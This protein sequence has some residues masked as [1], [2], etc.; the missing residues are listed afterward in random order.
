M[1]IKFDGNTTHWRSS[2]I[3]RVVE[4]AVV[5]AGPT[6]T[7]YVVY[8]MWAR[9][10]EASVAHFTLGDMVRLVI[11][12]PRRGPKNHHD[13]P[14][15]AIALSAAIPVDGTVL[16]MRESFRVANVVGHFVAV[17][18]HD[19]NG[20]T[21]LRP[22]VSIDAQPTWAPIETFVIR[23]YKDPKLDGTYRDFVAKKEK[24]LKRAEQDMERAEAEVKAAQGRLRKAKARKVAAAKSLKAAR[25]RRS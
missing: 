1:T 8:V 2:D 13:N 3:K 9:G 20:P 18:S 10:S 7:K 12:L 16:A 11:H 14:M 22:D 25:E 19:K 4:A 21:K 24:A 15:L 17:F 23:K 5:A 6:D